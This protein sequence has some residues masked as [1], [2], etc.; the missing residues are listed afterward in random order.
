M[1]PD[2]DSKN[3]ILFS[4]FKRLLAVFKEKLK[5]KSKRKDT[6]GFSVFRLPPNFPLYDPSSYFSHTA[7]LKLLVYLVAWIGL[8]IGSVVLQK[9][10]LEGGLLLAKRVKRAGGRRQ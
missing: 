5:K 1:T 7:L 6:P 10:R 3:G 4:I 2:S 9:K 8:N